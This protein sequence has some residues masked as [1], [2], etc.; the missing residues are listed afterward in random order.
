MTLS[1]SAADS[2][3][4]SLEAYFDAIARQ[5]ETPP[6]ALIPHFDALDA[7]ERRWSAETPPQLRHYLQKKSYQKALAFVRGEDAEGHS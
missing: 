6:P 4:Q 5:R 1:P 3:R 2:L 7:W